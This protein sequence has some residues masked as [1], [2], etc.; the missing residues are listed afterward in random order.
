MF[1]FKVNGQ[2]VSTER[3]MNLLDFI[4][5]ELR[6]TSLKNGCKEGSCGACMILVNGKKMRA[7]LLTTKK[8]DQMELLTVEGLSV[9]EKSVLVYC[10]Q[11]ADAVQCGFCTPG[12][13]ISAK[14]LFNEVAEPTATDV[15]RAVQG[16]LC[17]CTGYKKIEEAILMAARYLKEDRM[18]PV[19]YQSGRIGES[20]T[21]P[22]AKDKILGRAKYAQDYYEEGMVFGSALRSQYPRA[23][24]KGID[25]SRALMHP[26]L[27]RILLAEDIPG[28]RFLGHLT[29]DWPALIA[30]G[31]YTRYCGD[32]IALVA[33][34]TKKAL[35]EIKDLILVEYEVAQPVLSPREALLKEAPQ[36]H[37]GGNLYR[38]ERVYRGD[39]EQAIKEAAFIVTNTYK[40]PFQ[41]HAFLEPESA[42]A[43]PEEDGIKLYTGGQNIYDDQR[44][45]AALLGL[46]KEK[47]HV[48]SAVVG[49]GFGGKED[50]SVQHH[51]ALL[52]YHT[53]LPVQV[54]LTREE[55]FRVHPKRHPMEIEVT[56][57][58]DEKGRLTA[59]RLRLLAD[60]GAYASLGGPVL[61]RA[62]THAAGPYHYSNIDIIGQAV[63]TNNIPCG[64]F[65]GFGVTQSL[66]A[67]ECNLN[68]LA[69]KVGIDPFEIRYINAVRPG[70]T[71][72]NGQIADEGTG[73]VE[74]LDALRDVYYSNE[75]R[76]GI[77]CAIKNSGLGM[78]VEDIGRVKLVVKEH[79]VYLCTGAACMGQGIA[80]TMRSI[81]I[82]TTGLGVDQVVVVTP[83]TDVT[84]NSGT[85]T[86]SRQTLITGEATRKVAMLLQK[87]LRTHSL[88]DLDNKI[89][90]DDFSACTD[91]LGSRKENPVSHLAYGYAA[92]V[93]LLNSEGRVEKVIAAHDVGRAIHPKNVEGQIE[94]GIVMGLG[95]A[96]TEDLQMCNGKPK[97]RYHSL[98]LFRSVD[99]PWIETI[100][101]EKNPSTLAY[102]AKGVGEIPLIPTAPA[103]QGA[104][105]KWDRIFRRSLPLEDTPYRKNKKNYCILNARLITRDEQ[106]PFLNNA[107]IYIEGNRICGVGSNEEISGKYPEAEC[108]DAKGKILMPGLINTHHH[109]YSTFA[110]GMDFGQ[111]TGR[112]FLD[113]LKKIWWNL[114]AKLDL[115]A[116]YYSALAAYMECIRNGVTCV[117]DHHASYSSIRGS[118]YEISKAAKQLGVRTCLSYEVSDRKGK[119]RARE[120]IKESM[121]F[122]NYLKEEKEVMQRTLIGLHASFTVSDETLFACKAANEQGLPY[123]IHVAEGEYDD[124]HA[125]SHYGVS[126]VERLRQQGILRKGSLAGH[127]VHIS[128]EDMDILQSEGVVV[129]YNPQS[130]MNNAVGAPKVL[131]MMEKGILVCLGTDG[132]TADLLE[133]AKSGLLLQKH[134]TGKP[135]QG[136]D[137]IT[138][139]LFENNPKLAS[140]LFGETI[141]QIK[142][143]ALADVIL[144]DYSSFTPLNE[145]NYNAHLI[146]GATGSQVDTTIINGR[147][148]MKDKRLI[149]NEE[150]LYQECRQC[151]ER[152]WR[153]FDEESNDT[154]IF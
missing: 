23:L 92:Q 61:Q 112:D 108:I 79:K 124:E 126:V 102:G 26:E 131:R 1:S 8:V 20:T 139:M 56:T 97:A 15:K 38:E 74:C 114:D 49:G 101:I 55:S 62:C 43:I 89:Y 48:I 151:A 136:F 42:L 128:E 73:M 6:I 138:T 111:S 34:K 147:I 31:E 105:Y 137:E 57:A 82:E 29:K 54:T 17:R 30:V 106:R 77:A 4:R 64:A 10:F 32:G 66:F 88:I 25:L 71:L 60:T 118:L 100:L 87:D 81:L 154:P 150:I 125:R 115:E 132:Y 5:D 24:V 143:G 52:A 69:E 80:E 141:G 127:C 47:I 85:S 45:V 22:D 44:E 78:G 133:S 7:C 33:A 14:A 2:K 113:I 110:R 11:Q 130:N 144:L 98:G 153:K 37:S 72:P 93:V 9:R 109:I 53:R 152:L 116:V 50:M 134:A 70:E 65:R 123:H 149:M 103:L 121:E 59:M 27:V 129:V 16:N 135:E 120:A 21:R 145:K 63:Y 107:G 148:L 40:T 96:L 35:Q 75:A 41:E 84:P 140:S 36:I 68:Q 90:E 28:E 86:A 58:C 13:M 39:P 99:V 67:T 3:D 91:P 76:A 12:M 119:E 46:P 142:E 117:M 94:G 18:I 122:A 104:F 19:E 83:D 146:F 51:A 95:Y